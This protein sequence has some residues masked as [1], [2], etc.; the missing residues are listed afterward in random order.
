[1]ATYEVSARYKK[2][3]VETEYWVHSTDRNKTFEKELGW[4]WGRFTVDLS[5]ED[6]EA[7]DTEDDNGEFYP[8][9]YENCELL[10]C[11]DGCWE[12]WSFSEAI[13]DEERDEILDAYAEDY[14]EGLEELGYVLT[15]TEVVIQGPI[16]LEKVES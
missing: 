3:T 14:E 8:Y 16:D 10:E 1:M 6:L 11:T 13:T 2:S 12:D 4:R 5:E 7:L 9:G 15:D